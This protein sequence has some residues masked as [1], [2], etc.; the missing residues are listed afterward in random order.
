[1]E[2]LDDTVLNA[3]VIIQFP[4]LVQD[5]YSFLI[6]FNRH[7]IRKC[8]SPVASSYFTLFQ[9]RLLFFF[10]KWHPSSRLRKTWNLV[11]GLWLLRVSVSQ[12][13]AV[14]QLWAS[15]DHQNLSQERIPFSVSAFP[16]EQTF[17]VPKYLTDCYK[18]C[19]QIFLRE[20]RQGLYVQNLWEDADRS[21][22]ISV[23]LKTPVSPYIGRVVTGT[24]SN[25]I[26]F[27][28]QKEWLGTGRENI[29]LFEWIAQRNPCASMISKFYCILDFQLCC[30]KP[31]LIFGFSR[32]V[33]NHW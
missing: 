15:K 7:L 13:W 30:I 21:F 6:D 5:C 29:P 22:I 31:I 4:S 33:K 3:E 19:I 1:M 2:L 32:A 25:S 23:R 28:F 17:L 8:E 9:G 20:I 14:Y 18:A 12:T 24:Q 26:L 16:L 10:Y 27:Q 11:F